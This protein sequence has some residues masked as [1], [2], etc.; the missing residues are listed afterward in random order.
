M[1]GRAAS[2]RWKDHGGFEVSLWELWVLLQFVSLTMGFYTTTIFYWS[3]NCVMTRSR[4]IGT[5]INQVCS[6]GVERPELD[7]ANPKCK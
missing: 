7:S 3:I 2:A 5:N 1:C 6:G 4:H